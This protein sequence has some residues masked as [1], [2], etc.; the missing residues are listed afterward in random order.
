MYKMAVTLDGEYVHG[1]QYDILV[2]VY[3]AEDG[4]S[5]VSRK[6]NINVRPGT[7]SDTWQ[8]VSS[9]GDVGATGSIGP[10]GPTGPQGPAVPVIAN[11]NSTSDTDA[12]AASQ[13]K[14]LSERLS[15]VERGLVG[16]V[17]HLGNIVG[18]V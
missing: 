1:K 2:Q 6:R 17:A 11:L 5:Y 9:K 14:V 3:N 18:T 10:V 16:G 4:C 7:D 15:D 12:L 8:K 13:G